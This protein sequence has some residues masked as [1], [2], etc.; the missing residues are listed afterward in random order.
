MPSAIKKAREF[1]DD[2]AVIFVES[3]GATEERMERFA[4]DR[5]WMGTSAMWTREAPFRTGSRGLPNFALIGADGKI[6]MKGH[7][8]SMQSK[9]VKAIEEEIKKGKG[10][11]DGSPKALKSAYKALAKGDYAKAH[12]AAAKIAAKEGDDAAAATAFIES[13]EK[14]MG[15]EIARVE[16][17]LKNG[18]A[19]QADALYDELRAGAKGNDDF[20]ARVA[21]LTETMDTDE[22]SDEMKLDKAFGKLE[23]KL[24]ESGLDEKLLKKLRKMAEKNEGSR[25]MQ[26]ARRILDLAG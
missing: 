11:P 25:V 19:L 20:E 26:R 13:L 6:L 24:H 7:P 18:Y 5:G 15:K 3:Q 4:W 10:A 22:V 9:V 12:D 8:M 23:E 17:L 1:G 16:Y 2:L 14:R 21:A